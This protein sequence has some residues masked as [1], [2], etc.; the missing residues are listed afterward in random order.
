[1]PTSY[2]WPG[3]CWSLWIFGDNVEEVLGP[4]TLSVV[5]LACGLMGTILQVAVSPDSLVPTL[6]ASARSR[7]SWGPM[8]SGFPTTGCAFWSSGSSLRCPRVVV[9]GGWI[10]TQIWL[11]FGSI[12]HMGQAGGIAYLAHVGGAGPASSSRCRFI[13]TPSTSTP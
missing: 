6:G 13:T 2:I 11:G 10:I 8:S 1:M 7:G 5:Y 3:T 4:G 9:V 12:R